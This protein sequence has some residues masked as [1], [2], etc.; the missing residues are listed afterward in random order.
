MTTR[1]VLQQAGI[2]LLVLLIAAGSTAGQSASPQAN[3]VQT[4]TSDWMQGRGHNV[5][6]RN[7]DALHA[8]YGWGND[9]RGSVR[10]ASR[11]ATWTRQST[12]G[13]VLSRGGAGEWDEKHTAEPAVLY[14]LEQGQYLMWYS[15]QNSA[16]RWQIGLATSGDG[17][18]WSKH[19]GNPVLPVGAPG[20]WDDQEAAFG[21]VLDDGGTYH[22]WYSGYDGTNRR[23]GYASSVNGVSWLKAGPVLSGTVGAWDERLVGN[24]TVLYDGSTYHMW[25]GGWNPGDDHWRIGHAT[26]PDRVIWTKDPANPVLDLGLVG[27]WDDTH[28]Y[29]PTVLFDGHTF[30]M[31]Y[32]GWGDRDYGEHSPGQIGHA[33]STDGSTWIKDEDNPVYGPSAPGNWDS[34]WTADPEVLFDGD[35]YRLWYT[36]GVT[37]TGLQIGYATATPAYLQSGTYTSTLVSSGCLT[38]EL[39]VWDKLRVLQELNGQ[40]LTYA[41]LEESGRPVPGFEGMG[42]SGGVVE[43]NLSSLSWFYDRIYLRATFS[44]NDTAYSPVLEEWELLWSCRSAPYRAYLVVVHKP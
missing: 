36:G 4:S 38:D 25:Y 43:F 7:L 16:D 37:W 3:F 17:Q 9:A 21:T 11:P 33:T 31:G 30:H 12:A 5:D 13:P 14:D 6:R 35:L 20:A 27:S 18:T 41:I 1:T 24:P 23:I 26:S 42:A 32:A 22:M 2:V 8:P 29:A 10:L 44:T 15:G 34:M 28:V 39:T 40:Q 19:S